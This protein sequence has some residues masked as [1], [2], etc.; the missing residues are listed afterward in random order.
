MGGDLAPSSPSCAGVEMGG[1][2]APSSPG[3][4]GV[5]TG[6]GAVVKRQG[7][8]VVKRGGASGGVEGEDSCREA[9]T[10][11]SRGRTDGAAPSRVETWGRP[12]MGKRGGLGLRRPGLVG[13]QMMGPINPGRKMMW[14]FG[15]V[16]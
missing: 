8:G 3:C 1:D 7:G 10:A 15:P 11:E 6:G 16:K 2:L 4:A 9:P 5:E 13:F 12:G 14:G